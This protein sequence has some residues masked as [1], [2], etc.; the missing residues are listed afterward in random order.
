METNDYP[1]TAHAAD[2]GSRVGLIRVEGEGPAGGHTGHR[3]QRGFDRNV[4]AGCQRDGRPTTTGH[5]RGHC[6]PGNVSK[7]ARVHFEV[8][9]RRA[10]AFH[11]PYN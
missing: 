11:N 10:H 6:S 2:F 4:R 3:I 9:V 1:I 5:D 8:N 7:V